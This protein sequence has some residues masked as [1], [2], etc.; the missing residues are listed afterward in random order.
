MDTSTYDLPSETKRVVSARERLEARFTMGRKAQADLVNAVA[1]LHIKDKLVPPDKMGFMC[2][3]G[4]AF[5]LYDH[6]TPIRIHPHA[7][8]Q[9]AGVA[10]IP[11]L[12]V[13]RLING[14]PWEND[15]FAYNMGT[16]FQKGTYLDRKKNPTKFLN[17]LVGTGENEEVRGFLSRSFNRHLASLPLLR[18]FVMSCGEVQAQAIEAAVSPVRFSLK[19]YL[20][21]VFEPVEGEYVAIGTCWSNS[22]FGAG[23]LK[24]ALTA[25]R[26]SSGTASVLEDTLSR[27]HI[28]S[29]IEDSDIEL[30]EDTA[31][32]EVEAQAAAIRDAVHSQLAPAQ[33]NKVISAI[34]AAQEEAVPWHRIREVLGRILNKKEIDNVKNML[35]T[36]ISDIVDLPPPK[37]TAGGPQAT[38][39]WAANMLGWLGSK[40]TDADRRVSMQ[41]IAGELI[42][43]QVSP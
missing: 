12:Y 21:Y 11:K 30:S 4:S 24:L 20:P 16:L 39:W 23:R 2:H 32:K 41:E 15:L 19:M 10:G 37:M 6:G 28:G 26:V 29:I 17:R 8:T 1:G 14:E 7:L 38:R 27:V 22:D 25:M 35:E 36:G 33:V 43:A 5:V 18:A 34:R 42:Q 40:E 9:M 13:N 3:S 31:I